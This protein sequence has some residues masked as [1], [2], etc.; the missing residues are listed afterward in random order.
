M[1]IFYNTYNLFV[2]RSVFTESKNVFKTYYLS[3][4]CRRCPSLGGQKPSNGS[5]CHRCKSHPPPIGQQ[6]S[7]HNSVIGASNHAHQGEMRQRTALQYVRTKWC[8]HDRSKNWLLHQDRPCVVLVSE[9][10][11]YVFFL[12]FAQFCLFLIFHLNFLPRF[13]FVF[14]F[15]FF[16]FTGLVLNKQ[17]SAKA[18]CTGITA[19]TTKTDLKPYTNFTCT[20]LVEVQ[21]VQFEIYQTE[22]CSDAPLQMPLKNDACISSDDGG[23]ASKFT[24]DTSSMITFS[25]Y[26]DPKKCDGK[27]L[28]TV[29][30]KSDDGKCYNPVAPG[31]LPNSPSADASTN[32]LA[33]GFAVAGLIVSL[34]LM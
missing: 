18:D 33:T 32:A 17:D 6:I 12:Y 11:R 15:V 10:R 30:F 29:S 34:V 27:V 8:Y 3:C 19:S 24:C 21:G 26:K 2:D 14:V 16:W 7:R 13:C 22:D 20:S 5:P 9:M 1:F 4:T 23:V 28:N 25:G 31:N